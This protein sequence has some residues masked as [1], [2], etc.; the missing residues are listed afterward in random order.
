LEQ[1]QVK[2][3]AISAIALP[4]ALLK[5]CAEKSERNLLRLLT[6]KVNFRANALFHRIRRVTHVALVTN[7]DN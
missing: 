3:R 5:I 6:A 7:C 1:T 4:L 2:V